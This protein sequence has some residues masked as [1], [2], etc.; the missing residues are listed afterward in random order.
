MQKYFNIWSQWISLSLTCIISTVKP[1]Q[2]KLPDIPTHIKQAKSTGE[3][4]EIWGLGISGGAH[5]C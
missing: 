5:V 1:I 4:N 3:E 2:A